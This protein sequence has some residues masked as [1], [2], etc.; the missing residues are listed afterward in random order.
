MRLK[1]V[2]EGPVRGLVGNEENGDRL[3]SYVA[4]KGGMSFAQAGTICGRA[5]LAKGVVELRRSGHLVAFFV[6]TLSRLHLIEL[7]SR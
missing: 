4:R 7:L 6:A 2:D 5:S 1:L 3:T